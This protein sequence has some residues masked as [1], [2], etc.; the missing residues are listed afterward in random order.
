MGQIS[1]A[2]Y[3]DLPSRFTFYSIPVPYQNHELTEGCEHCTTTWVA[4]MQGS[5]WSGV[6]SIQAC[7]H[8]A[9]MAVQTN[10][11]IKKK[12]TYTALNHCKHYH[13]HRLLSLVKKKKTPGHLDVFRLI[14]FRAKT[15]VSLGS[16]LLHHNRFCANLCL[17]NQP[18]Y[19]FQ[20]LEFLSQ[21]FIYTAF[22][23]PHS[24]CFVNSLFP[25]LCCICVFVPAL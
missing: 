22:L 6:I 14:T 23:L 12:K 2:G 16:Q 5:K 15:S 25:F 13:H 24:F 20:V 4:V 21:F 7:C 10:I 3:S 18:D 8:K 11:Q 19:V 9:D 1:D 17:F